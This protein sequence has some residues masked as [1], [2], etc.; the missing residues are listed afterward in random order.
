MFR[1]V[2]Q[3]AHITRRSTQEVDTFCLGTLS[4]YP[5]FHVLF[6]GDI[7]CPLRHLRVKAQL[8]LFFG[9]ECEVESQEIHQ[10]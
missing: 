3:G 4:S 8:P 1:L 6:Q 9:F 2:D 10:I 7:F 5:E